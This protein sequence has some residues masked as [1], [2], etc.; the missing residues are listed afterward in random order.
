M[1]FVAVSLFILPFPIGLLETTLVGPL[2]MTT[3]AAMI[4]FP[5][6]ILLLAASALVLGFSNRKG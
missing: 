2:F 5:V 6:G 4:G 1:A 3:F